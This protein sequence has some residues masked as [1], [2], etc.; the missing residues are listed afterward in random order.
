M[1][2]AIAGARPEIEER[3]SVA[4]EQPGAQSERLYLALAV[5]LTLLGLGLR[6]YRIDYQSLWHDEAYTLLMAR[7][8]IEKLIVFT[9]SHEHPPLLYLVLHIL[10]GVYGSYLVPRVL[11]AIAGGLSVLVLY[12]LGARLLHPVA[13]LVAGLLLAVSPFHLWHSQDGRA[14][15]L[16]GLFVLLSYLCVFAVLQNPRR[17]LWIA[18]TVCTIL[19]LYTDYTAIPVLI[20]QALL[21]LRAR[22]RRQGKQLFMAWG[23]VTLAFAP[24]VVAF[25][26]ANA[27]Q[28]VERFWIPPPTL[29]AVVN[30]VLEFLGFRT[31]CPTMTTCVIGQVPLPLLAG[32][33]WLVASLT[34]A[35]VLAGPVYAWRR[36]DLT[37]GVLA[38]WLILPFALVLLM[39]I[40]RSLYI[41][42]Y[43]VLATFP[44]YLLLGF[45]VIKAQWRRWTMILAAGIIAVIALASAYDVGLT[46][47]RVSKPDWKSAMRDFRAEYRPGQAVA[48]YP[49]IVQT[50][51]AEY[52]SKSWHPARQRAVWL[53]SYLDVPGWQN[54]YGTWTDNQL[55]SMQLANVTRGEQ[56]LWLVT[57]KYVGLWHVHHWLMAHGFRQVLARSYLGDVYLE[58]WNRVR[59]SGS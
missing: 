9:G 36:R 52:L 33:E 40:V 4:P 32:H 45:G 12:L 20:P 28:V 10:F 59:P 17:V 53:R 35:A 39:A 18:Y 49:G 11:S 44:F 22:E 30:T 3:S 6:L 41:D 8:P 37:L 46:Y 48:F 29:D 47:T 21:L 7:F 57:D 13:G 54:R 43:F 55:R 34:V 16:A 24:W 50:L 19:A 2:E 1:A 56:Q 58:R 25:A 5:A 38:L 31:S 27:T 26:Y 15:V 23:I 14:R 51:T 42:R